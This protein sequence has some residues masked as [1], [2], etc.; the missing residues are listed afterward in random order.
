M[1]V[2]IR[3]CVLHKFAINKKTKKE[4]VGPQGPKYIDSLLDL[5]L[6]IPEEMSVAA[7][8]TGP[9]KEMIR[10]QNVGSLLPDSHAQQMQQHSMAAEQQRAR[11]RHNVH[12]LFLEDQVRFAGAFCRLQY[13]QQQCLTD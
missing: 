13:P 8:N 2:C 4:I 9:G 11:Q 12:V 7:K 6:S 3:V 5:L 10:L 1:C